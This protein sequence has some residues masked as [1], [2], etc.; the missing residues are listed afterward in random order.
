M[1]NSPEAAS[2]T[3]PRLDL[4]RRAGWEYAENRAVSEGLLAEI[5]SPMIPE[6]IYAEIVNGGR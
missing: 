4:V 3:L 5:C 6:D 2:V 1:F